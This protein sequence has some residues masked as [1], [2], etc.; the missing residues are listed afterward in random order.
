MT[1][2]SATFNCRVIRAAA[3]LVAGC[4]TVP[5]DT[6]SLTEAAKAARLPALHDPN[7]SSQDEIDRAVASNPIAIAIHMRALQIV[8]ER[9]DRK[10]TPALIER[11][12]A[13]IEAGLK[14]AQM[15]A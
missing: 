2:K 10:P 14:S 7:L 4:K 1:M 6:K 9:K 8:D 13:L 5:T 11:R 15:A 12:K 3:Y